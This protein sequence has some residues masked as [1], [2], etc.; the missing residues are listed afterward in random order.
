MEC[1]WIIIGDWA[2]LYFGFEIEL[3]W[4][5][6]RGFGCTRSA[7][8]I[9]DHPLLW[10]VVMSQTYYPEHIFAYGSGKTCYSLVMGSGSFLIDF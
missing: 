10:M 9:E 3:C 5:I 7:M 1:E 2:E 8:S 4:A 6:E